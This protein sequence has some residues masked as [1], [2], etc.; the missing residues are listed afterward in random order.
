MALRVARGAMSFG[1]RVEVRAG[2]GAAV[3][4]VAELV[5]VHA[6]LGGGVVAFDVVGY[7]CGGGFGGLFEGYGASDGGVTAEDCDWGG[8]GV[9]LGSVLL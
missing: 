8:D 9:S 1:K 3:G 7:G 2:G 5:D 4:V 6:A